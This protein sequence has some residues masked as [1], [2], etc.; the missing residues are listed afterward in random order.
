MLYLDLMT[1]DGGQVYLDICSVELLK[2]R[3]STG[4]SV[5]GVLGDGYC[6]AQVLVEYIN[7]EVSLTFIDKGWDCF[8]ENG[9]EGEDLPE[10]LRLALQDE[11]G[12]AGVWVNMHAA[13]QSDAGNCSL[14]A[15]DRWHGTRPDAV[16]DTGFSACK[17]MEN[18]PGWASGETGLQDRCF[19]MKPAVKQ[20][21]THTRSLHAH[22]HSRL[23]KPISPATHATTG[24]HLSG[25]GA[26]VQGV[27]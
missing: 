21:Q 25:C 17:V 27:G 16:S 7:A 18:A 2:K 6:E 3:R 4:F 5:Q 10:A 1:Q 15:G 14:L 8:R 20:V 19:L 12:Q 22:S 24:T 9:G 23:D 26:S 11:L 13:D